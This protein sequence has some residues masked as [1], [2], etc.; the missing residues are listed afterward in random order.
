MQ[1]TLA[2]GRTHQIRVHAAHVGHPLA[3]DAKYG[4]KEANRR[5]RER[6]LKRLFLHAAHLDFE[7]EGRSYAFSTPLPDELKTFLDA[8]GGRRG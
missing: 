5:F 4:D 6:G 8:L 3:G 2:T 1:A 7:W